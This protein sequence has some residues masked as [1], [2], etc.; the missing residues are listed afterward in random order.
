MKYDNSNV[1]R[2]QRLLPENEAYELLQNGE[3]GVLAMEAETGGGYG[4]PLSYVVDEDKLY[5][6]CAKEGEKLRCI[7]KEPHVSFVVVGKTQVVSEKFTTLYNSIVVK[8]KASIGLPAQERRHA[9]ELI[10]DKYSPADKEIGMKYLEKSFDRTEIVRIDIEN[11][12]GKS[13]R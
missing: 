4:I 11:M 10:L 7:Q 3:Y 2:Q 6:H 12:T 8:G 13:K 9:L 1:R 5:F